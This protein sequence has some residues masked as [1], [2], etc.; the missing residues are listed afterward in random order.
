[1]IA[2]VMMTE[3]TGVGQ[4]AFEAIADL[5]AHLVL[6]R[7]NEQQHAIVLLGFAKLPE[8]EELIGIGLDVAALQ[9]LHGGND[10]LDAGFVLERPSTSL[11][12]RCG[13]TGDMTSA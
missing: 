2:L 5:D 11:R 3:L 1:M 6:G 7:R 8:A 9:R 13:V 10:E 4:R 12:R